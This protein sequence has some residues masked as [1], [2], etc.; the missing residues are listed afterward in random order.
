MGWGGP[1]SLSAFS[2]PPFSSDDYL[3][4]GPYLWTGAAGRRPVPGAQPPG[5]VPAVTSA[6]KPEPSP[7]R[8]PNVLRI[9]WCHFPPLVSVHK[10]HTTFPPVCGTKYHDHWSLM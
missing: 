6:Y 5:Y 7:P 1:A 9:M 2:V 8:A 4:T 10:T 3:H